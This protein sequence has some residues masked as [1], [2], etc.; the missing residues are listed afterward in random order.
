M[1]QTPELP[2]RR[3]PTS[4]RRIALLL[5]LAAWLAWLLR[6]LLRLCRLICRDKASPDTPRVPPW[7]Y[8]QPDPLI[9]SQ[10]YLQAQGLAVTWNNPDVRLESPTA[11]GV[12]VDSHALEADTDYLVIATVWNG[13]T[14][15]PAVGLPVHV[16][17]LEFGIGTIRHDIGRTAVDLAVKGG[18]GC[19]AHATVPWHTPMVPGH[20]CLQIELL[21]NDDANPA[22][23][24]GQHNT[25]VKLLNSPNAKF[26]FP[27]RNDAEAIRTLRLEADSYSIP[28]LEECRAEVGRDAARRRI[29]GHLRSAWPMPAGWQVVIDPAEPRLEPGQTATVNVDVTA[30]D[31]YHGRQ[32]MNVNAYAGSKLVGGVTFYIEGSGQ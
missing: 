10:T 4:V 28:P 32:A 30:P 13:S 3:R 12:P 27:L 31:A 15:A 17:F 14:A 22:N 19:P 20:Y 18:L 16:S 21:W 9:Y 11:P 26:D 1:S 5:L 24:M 25:D 7:A 2:E 6:S 23:N 8:R 29:A